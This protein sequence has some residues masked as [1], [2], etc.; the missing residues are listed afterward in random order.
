M[1]TETWTANE[2]GP[3]PVAAQMSLFDSDLET[4]LVRLKLSR[5]DVQRWYKRGWLS[6][7]EPGGDRCDQSHEAELN[8]VGAL[9][10]FGLGDAMVDKLLASLPKPYCY[11]ARET[12]YSFA[13]ERWI[14][15]PEAREADYP[16]ESYL[17]KLAE[18]KDW[19]ALE[20]VR[21]AA[22]ALL[23]TFVEDE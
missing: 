11:D 18:R 14:G 2:L 13:Q 7:T 16:V 6:F 10:R 22:D 19:D 9:A 12:F 3:R 15:L 21:D 23:P 5:D 17:E 1:K 4:L 8:F 20:E